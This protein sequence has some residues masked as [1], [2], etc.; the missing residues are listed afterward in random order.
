M[1]TKTAM[2]LAAGR[3]ERMRPLTDKV[4]KPLLTVQGKALIEHH[5]LALKK[6]G[7]Q[8]VVINHAW[9]GKQI[10]AQ[11]GDG[12]Q[13]AL[14]ILYS[15]EQQAL[16]TAGGIVQALPL[17]CQNEDES[18]FTVVNGDVFTDFDFNELPIEIS[19]GRAHLVLVN[20]P[21][22]NLKGDFY[23]AGQKLVESG[24]KKLT[25]SGIAK[26]HKDFFLGQEVE[27]KSLVP[28]F[29]DGISKQT[30]TAQ[31]YMGSWTDVGTPQRLEQLNN[32]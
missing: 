19:A 10:E 20:N 3:G 27:V 12:K 7:Y 25:F 28:L 4:P 9:L 30:I 17:L 24:Q 16:E 18:C 26:Y 23:L 13:F 11:L 5:L 21:E 15:P 1:T 22:H 8:R 14:E 32:S 31:H 29:F 2:I 6:A